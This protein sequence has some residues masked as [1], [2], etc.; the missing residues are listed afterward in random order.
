MFLLSLLFFFLAH[1]G[2]LDGGGVRGISSLYVLKAIMGK[3]GL[4]QKE[5]PIGTGKPTVNF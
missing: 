3:I 4:S 1:E 2:F 5:A